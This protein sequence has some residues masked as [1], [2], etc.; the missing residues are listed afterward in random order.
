MPTLLVLGDEYRALQ[1]PGNE[2]AA[3]GI[4]ITKLTSVDDS[5]AACT[6]TVPDAILIDMHSFGKDGFRSIAQLRRI[7]PKT[8][9]FAV[10]EWKNVVVKH[11]AEQAG[12][13]AYLSHP[14]RMEPIVAALSEFNKH[15]SACDPLP[16]R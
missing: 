1:L 6:R 2:L 4:R 11:Y 5:L 7:A 15:L 9:I 3:K 14:L 13:T 16:Y 12:A 8:P 10:G